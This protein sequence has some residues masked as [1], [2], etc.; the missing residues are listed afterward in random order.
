MDCGMEFPEFIVL[1]FNNL[2]L[3]NYGNFSKKIKRQ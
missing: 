3:S 1:M 2:K